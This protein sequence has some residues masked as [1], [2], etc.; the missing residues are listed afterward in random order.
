M[1]LS[2]G[3]QHHSCDVPTPNWETQ[4]DTLVLSYESHLVLFHKTNAE[5]IVAMPPLYTTVH[6]TEL[7][8]CS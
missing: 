3:F 1:S 5:V 4:S 6:W 7:L 2:P 8:Y